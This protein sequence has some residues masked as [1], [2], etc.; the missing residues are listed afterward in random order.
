M[1]SMKREL[2]AGNCETGTDF[3]PAIPVGPIHIFI[4]L[5][6]IHRRIVFITLSQSIDSE[7]P[8]EV[9]NRENGKSHI[10]RFL[11]LF[12]AILGTLTRTNFVC[13]DFY[14]SVYSGICTADAVGGVFNIGWTADYIS[15][16]PKWG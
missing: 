11:F 12:L 4:Y 5:A 16:T 9:A 7:K 2:S 10:F 1:Y 15:A 8:A 13:E 14:C 3:H 6:K